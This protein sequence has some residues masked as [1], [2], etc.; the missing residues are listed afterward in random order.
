VVFRSVGSRG[1]LNGADDEATDYY[2]W[3]RGAFESSIRQVGADEGVLWYWESAVEAAV[4][5][6][7]LPDRA[8]KWGPPYWLI[9]LDR[10]RT[11]AEGAR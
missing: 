5:D 10:G 4:E 2:A 1:L 8:M 7:T 9:S 11:E 3:F 6:G